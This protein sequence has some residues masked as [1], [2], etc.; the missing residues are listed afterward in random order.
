MYK[1]LFILF[2]LLLPLISAQEYYA[3]IEIEVFDDGS[4][5]IDGIS[6][7]PYL[8]NIS[9][10]QLY[11]SKK[12]EFWLFN[13]TTDVHFEDFIFK[14]N[15]PEGV[16]INYIKTTPQFRIEDNGESLSIIGLGEDRELNILVQYKINK[17]YSFLS[18]EQWIAFLLGL[19]VF[20]LIF[21]TIFLI[22]SSYGPKEIKFKSQEREEQI[23][24]LDIL[25]SRQK[26]IIEII[27]KEKKIS[28]KDL[29]K[30]M[31]IPKSSVSRNVNSLI[32]RNI[33][34]KEK[35]GIT[36]FLFLKK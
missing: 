16:E 27:K 24:N 19:L 2:L 12:G 14:L 11:T 17:K 1:Q 5:T 18:S 15:L 7:Y 8:Q 30:I 6:N 20:S 32:S 31:N 25:P 28:Q 9:N 21:G 33:L 22:K 34:D 3:D 23:F 10:S 36:T 13:L 29:V 4:T 35:V 26:Q